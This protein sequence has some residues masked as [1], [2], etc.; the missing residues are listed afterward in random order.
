[1][2]AF[3]QSLLWLLDHSSIKKDEK[4]EKIAILQARVNDLET[5]RKDLQNQI[6]ELK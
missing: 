3:K 2:S 5:Q 1:M 6:D 4:A